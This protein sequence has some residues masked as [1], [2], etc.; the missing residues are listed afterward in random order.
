MI[1]NNKRI[2]LTNHILPRWQGTPLANTYGGKTVL[3]YKG[4]PVFAEIY[5]LRNYKEAGFEGVWVDNF[6]GLFR[7]G[8]SVSEDVIKLPAIIR[9]RLYEIHQD[10][11]LGG[12]WDLLLWKGDKIK[13]VE[14][15]KKGKDKI[16][17]N[18]IEF[19]EKALS[20]GHTID[21]FELYEWEVGE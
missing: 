5:A 14:L 7:T 21:A 9:K 15:K 2:K 8:M 17:D 12:T 18:Q 16:R 10:G 4:E 20:V 13:F 6:K 11:K 3:N 1:L 19:L